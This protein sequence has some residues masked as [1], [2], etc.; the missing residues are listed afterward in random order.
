M[1]CDSVSGRRGWAG[2]VGGGRGAAERRELAEGLRR[3]SGTKCGCCARRERNRTGFSVPRDG[4]R[5]SC[6]VIMNVDF[7]SVLPDQTGE[8]NTHSR[9][10]EV[11]S[12][13]HQMLQ[14]C[15]DC[16]P[17]QTGSLHF[18]RGHLCCRHG[19]LTQQSRVNQIVA[20]YWTVSSDGGLDVLKACPSCYVFCGVFFLAFCSLR[21]RYFSNNFSC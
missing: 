12:V 14:F 1:F 7:S 8:I 16:S 5:G 18:P 15:A 13:L 4:N 19:N 17:K 21:N 3:V 10:R 6:F 20:L 2:L 9:S 11:K